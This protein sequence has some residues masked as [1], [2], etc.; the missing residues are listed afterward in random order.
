MKKARRT[1]ILR[2]IFYVLLVRVRG[3][4]AQGVIRVHVG[5]LVDEGRGGR[6]G[7]AG[8]VHHHDPG[9]PGAVLVDPVGVPN[10]QP[11]AAVGGGAA[12]LLVL[13][14]QHLLLAVLVELAIVPADGHGM[15]QVV[16]PEPAGVL[17][18]DHD[19]VHDRHGLV[20]VLAVDVVGPGRGLVHGV[21]AGA[22]HDPLHLP[23]SVHGQEADHALATLE[24]REPPLPVLPGRGLG[25]VG[26]DEEV[27][28]GLQRRAVAG[29][30]RCVR[31]I[32]AQRPL[33]EAAEPIALARD[34]VQIP[35]VLLRDQGLAQLQ[36]GRGAGRAEGGDRGGRGLRRRARGGRGRRRRRGR[37]GR[38]RLRRRQ[39]RGLRRGLWRGRS[40]RFPG[41]G[42][43]RLLSDVSADQAQQEQ[44]QP[45]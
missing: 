2:A 41:R 31:P 18:V 42:R 17:G 43:R 12:Q 8:Q 27:L 32:E 29:L 21:R 22:D 4:P 6:G 40:R 39:G 45:Q 15:E 36:K 13:V 9:A 10:Q 38:R 30:P 44:Q 7:G 20:G 14:D 28:E 19:A 34:L 3:V 16:A 35:A 11:H 5:F 25:G 24:D 37:R 1:K 23:L 26:G 33:A